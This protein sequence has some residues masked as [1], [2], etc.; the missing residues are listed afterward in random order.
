MSTPRPDARR[1]PAIRVLR[2]AAPAELDGWDARTVDV[3][4]GDVQQSFA[5]A[6]HRERTG[7]RAHRLVLE[8]GSLVVVLGRPWRIVGGGRAYVPKGPAA[9]G[10]PPATPGAPPAVPATPPATGAAPPV[11]AAAPAVVAARLDG[12]AGWA[13]AAGYDVLAADP[14]IPAD[15]GFPALL[16]GAGFRQVEEVGPSRHRVGVPIPPGAFE[17]ALLHAMATTTRQR[18]LSA[19]RRGIRVVRY[20]TRAGLDPGPGV[21]APDPMRLGA[22]AEEAFA[23]FHALLVATGERRG[24][25]VGSRP[26]A[27]AWWRAALESGHLLLLEARGLEDEVV[28]AAI[29]YRHGR[30]LTY[31]SSGDVP[32]LRSTYPGAMGLVLWRALQLAA[33]EGRVE[34][35]LG[36]VDVRGARRQPLPGEP[37]YGLLRFKESFGGTWI[38]LAGAHERVLRR[39]R[40]AL[41]TGAQRAGRAVRSVRGAVRRRGRGAP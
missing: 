32:A 40:H 2:E 9:P 34:L 35:D 18:F 31:S 6:A 33:R 13:R 5:W 36:G 28:A 41:V 17:E 15:G 7:W 38:E 19:E 27:L 25:R 37:T 3:P 22:A 20:D 30:R 11:S 1:L 16:A 23:R 4:G 21:E 29:F 39:P 8:D 26:I 12:I 14:E 10:L 24:F